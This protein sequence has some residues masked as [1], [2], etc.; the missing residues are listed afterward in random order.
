[1]DLR[2]RFD[3]VETPVEVAGHRWTLLHPRSAEALISEPDFEKDERLPYWADLWPS[4]RVLADV[5]ARHHGNGRR[6]LELG[7]GSGLVAC[8]LASAGYAV[9]ASD[10]YHEAL[11]FTAE[12]V[13]RACG[14]E[15][16]TMH[17]DWR[18]LPDELPMW[19]L[20]VG[21]DVLYERPYGEIVAGV[22]DRTV[23]PG[24]A[25]I[26]ADPGRI[27][28]EPFMDAARVRGLT[29]DEGWEVPW[30]QEGQRHT[31]RVRVLVRR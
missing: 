27:A 29:L 4:S 21:A 26:I 12:N 10:Y 13:R 17:L 19:D 7:C 9:T 16:A 23:A 15:I 30:A 14:V 8:A 20:V 1:M 22:L 24:G 18:T 31:V 3:V 25:A 6:A 5:L 11:A 2:E 28:L